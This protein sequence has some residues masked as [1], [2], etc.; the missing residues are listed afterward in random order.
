MLLSS[1]RLRGAGTDNSCTAATNVSKIRHT[2]MPSPTRS[3]TRRIRRNPPSATGP[4]ASLMTLSHGSSSVRPASCCGANSHNSTFADLARAPSFGQQ[5]VDRLPLNRVVRRAAAFQS[6]ERELST[7]CGHPHH[8]RLNGRYLS[9]PAFR[10]ELPRT[11]PRPL[12]SVSC[13]GPAT[14]MLT[15]AATRTRS[16]DEKPVSHLR[17]MNR[18]GFSRRPPAEKGT[19]FRTPTGETS[20]A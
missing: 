14:A 4:P 13:G 15:T 10:N 9:G 19:G 16:L 1:S 2:T 7:H 3:T 5:C 20:F 12:L 18:P 8:H 11:R 17:T 6:C